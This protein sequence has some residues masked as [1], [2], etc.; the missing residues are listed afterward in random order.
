MVKPSCGKTE[1]VV[2]V[3]NIFITLKKIGFFLGGFRIEEIIRN[4]IDLIEGEG[5]EMSTT[6]A[7][8]F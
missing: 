5:I 4:E 8:A 7:F 1:C 2:K 3:S 6:N